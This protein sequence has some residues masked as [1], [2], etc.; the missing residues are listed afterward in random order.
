M[1]PAKDR[2]ILELY[3]LADLPLSDI[4]ELLGIDETAAQK[5]L[6]RA[7]KGAKEQWR[8]DEGIRVV[9]QRR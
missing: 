2:Q 6:Q 9:L 3:Y 4:A 8:D 5:R 7:R 1:L